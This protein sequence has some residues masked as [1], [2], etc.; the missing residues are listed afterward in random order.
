M[1]PHHPSDI[2]I[3]KVSR[4][5]WE[6]WGLWKR[7]GWVTGWGVEG[8]GG[9]D[10]D[11]A[12]EAGNP[13]LTMNAVEAPPTE[14]GTPAAEPPVSGPSASE[15]Q[16]GP[17]P[18]ALVS[19]G[20]GKVCAA[21]LTKDDHNM[22]ECPLLVAVA[23]GNEADIQKAKSYCK[24]LSRLDTVDTD[25]RQWSNAH[26]R[27]WIPIPPS[28]I[29]LIRPDGHC[30]F[31]AIFCSSYLSA[32]RK[33]QAGVFDTGPRARQAWI[34]TA[35]KILLEEVAVGDASVPDAKAILLDG[36]QT[37]EQYLELMSQSPPSR[38]SWG[39][40]SE[41]HMMAILWKCRICTLL[42]RQDPLEGSQVRLLTGPLGTTGHIHTLLFNG[43]HY[44]FVILTQEQ[45][46][47]LG[48]L[49]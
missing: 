16:A 44:D 38:E 47:L 15:P 24:G 35:R 17:G 43:S 10:L 48:L 36:T 7:V 6:A 37:A 20:K 22:E 2:Y 34:K 9:F 46:T 11:F 1:P 23:A 32:G 33:L 5:Q 25:V 13:T 4:G 30:L 14:A 42:S 49:P 41:L 27:A 39:G 45:M 19:S 12:G 18:P 40:E 26:G 21:C 8:P 31:A 3:G 29:R 28:Q